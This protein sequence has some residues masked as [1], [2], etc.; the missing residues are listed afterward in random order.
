M[1]QAQRERLKGIE[2]SSS[3]WKTERAFCDQGQNTNPQFSVPQDTPGNKGVRV[4][5][6]T[7]CSP[8]SSLGGGVA[9]RSSVWTILPPKPNL[10]CWSTRLLTRDR[11]PAIIA[12][13]EAED[14]SDEVK[15]ELVLESMIA[16]ADGAWHEFQLPDWRPGTVDMG[17]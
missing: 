11:A 5:L 16:L 3:V 4:H 1:G 2:P 17:W 10:C 6:L 13:H 9:L 12:G 15:A 7:K 8:R 14:R